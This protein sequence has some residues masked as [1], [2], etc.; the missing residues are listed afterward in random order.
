MTE[1]HQQKL[2]ICDY[3]QEEAKLLWDMALASG[4]MT[5]LCNWSSEPT[6]ED[7]E[8]TTSN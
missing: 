5:T 8:P 7:D 4:Q 1:P 6:G 3:S 2:Y